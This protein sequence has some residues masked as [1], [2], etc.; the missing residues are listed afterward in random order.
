MLLSRACHLTVTT[1][2]LLGTTRLDGAASMQLGGGSPVRTL[3]LDFT[4]PSVAADW[5]AVDD[6]IMGGA[7]TSSMVYSDADGATRFE[8]NLIVEGGGFA[9]VRF[10]PALELNAGVEALAVEAR[11]DGRMGYKVTLT[12]AAAPMGVSY[13]CTLPPLRQDAF[14]RVKLPLAQFRPSFRGRAAPEAPALRAADVTGLGLMLSRYAA[15]GSDVAAKV[16]I[17]PGP[18]A[19]QLRRLEAAESDLAINGR[20][21]VQARARGGP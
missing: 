12:S 1:L 2:Q 6:R 11:G 21:W 13:Q 7:T 8:G 9:S 20:R 5:L 16:D 10:G 19:L 4:D 14:E 17:A 15:E 3:P 18:F